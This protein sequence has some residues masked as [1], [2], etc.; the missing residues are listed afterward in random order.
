MQSICEH[1]L[2]FLVDHY[3]REENSFV[4][5]QKFVLVHQS[6][7]KDEWDYLT[8]LIV[9]DHPAIVVDSLN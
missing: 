2:D 6:I 1:E 7:G 8:S 5:T 9:A 4:K 3:A